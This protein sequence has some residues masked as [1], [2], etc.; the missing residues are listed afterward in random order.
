MADQRVRLTLYERYLGLF[1]GY[2]PVSRKQPGYKRFAKMV[3]RAVGLSSPFQV[4]RAGGKDERWPLIQEHLRPADISLLDIGCN[5]GWFTRRAAEA[6]LFSIGIEPA[7]HVLH[8]ARRLHADV[9]RL[10]FMREAVTSESL[11][12]LPRF[13]VILCLSVH[14]YWAEIHDLET[15]WAMIG[16]L[17]ELSRSQMFFEPASRRKKYGTAAPDFVDNDF[18]SVRAYNQRELERVAG[19]GRV[20]SLV[21]RTPALRK[22]PF[23]LLFRIDCNPGA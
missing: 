18:E 3:R 9:P 11:D 22:E 8:A 14:H 16:R 2:D 1:D 20:V 13:D 21:A 15:A 5:I 12:T 10:A 6:G 7:A 19:P 23:R 17:I 4:T